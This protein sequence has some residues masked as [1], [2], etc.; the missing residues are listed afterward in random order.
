M[1]DLSIVNPAGVMKIVELQVQ[2]RLAAEF[3]QQYKAAREDGHQK[4]LEIA[5]EDTVS[6]SYD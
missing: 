6:T 5:D 4:E 2:A 3:E 1:R